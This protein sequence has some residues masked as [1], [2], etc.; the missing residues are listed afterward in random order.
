LVSLESEW[1]QAEAGRMWTLNRRGRETTDVFF[2]QNFQLKALS[3]S[4]NIENIK[5]KRT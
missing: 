5:V 2:P 4:S 1:E 3:S